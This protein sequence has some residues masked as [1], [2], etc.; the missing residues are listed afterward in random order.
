[1]CQLK[2]AKRRYCKWFHSEFS[3]CLQIRLEARFLAL[4]LRPD[5]GRGSSSY[6]T[7]LNGSGWL[8]VIEH[9]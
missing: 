2:K 5:P 4:L 7:Q 8:P 6:L 1:M 9:F 3:K